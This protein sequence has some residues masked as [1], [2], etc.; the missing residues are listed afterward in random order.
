MRAI[1]HSR[2]KTEAELVEEISRIAR[3]MFSHDLWLGM[4]RSAASYR[5]EL[6]YDLANRRDDGE[7]K[8]LTP[9]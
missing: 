6:L 5:E 8:R 4:G 2:F 7:I 3:V 1:F 9:R